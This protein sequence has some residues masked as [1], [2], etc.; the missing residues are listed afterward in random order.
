MESLRSPSYVIDE[1]MMS[2]EPEELETMPKKISG[3]QAWQWLGLTGFIKSEIP[4]Y[5][6]ECKGVMELSSCSP[7]ESKERRYHKGRICMAS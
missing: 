5:H 7:S 2:E 6:S 4:C 3:H 1:E